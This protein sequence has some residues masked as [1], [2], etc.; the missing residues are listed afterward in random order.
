MA[1]SSI[2]LELKSTY[3]GE[4]FKKANNAVKDFSRHAKTATDSVSKVTHALGA[5]DSK[6]GKI[7]GSI[8]NI[9]GS[10]ARG[11]VVGLAISGITA[12]FSL[13]AN[14]IKEAE[15]RA[16]EAAEKIR[17]DFE[18]AF[19]R[20]SESRS[21]RDFTQ[22]LQFR[23]SRQEDTIQN[24]S[25]ETQI[26]SETYAIRKAGIERR[27]DLDEFQAGVDAAQERQTL[28][29]KAREKERNA[30]ELKVSSTE[31]ELEAKRTQA[32][33]ARDDQARDREDYAKH[34]AETLKPLM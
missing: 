8:G 28:N 16:K 18:R 33:N 4:G 20:I 32:R 1:K 34:V 12:A 10:F 5:L 17:A 19:Q 3:N 11:G 15:E 24:A 22:A 30:M 13:V 23:T 21:F 31:K 7:A 9:F 25:Q 2:E 6:A 26:D 14:K 27:R 29:E